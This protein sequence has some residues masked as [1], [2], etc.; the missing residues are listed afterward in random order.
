M[1]I[2]QAF[3]LKSESKPNVISAVICAL[4]SSCRRRRPA[5][6]TRPTRRWPSSK[7]LKFSPP[8]VWCWCP[9]WTTPKFSG[10]DA[11]NTTTNPYISTNILLSYHHPSF[12]KSTCISLF[13]IEQ[14][15]LGLIYTVHVDGLSVPLETVI[16]N[17]LTC[18]IPIAGGSQVTADCFYHTQTVKRHDTSWSGTKIKV[19][20]IILQVCFLYGCS[21]FAQQRSLFRHLSNVKLDSERLVTSMT[22]ASV[23]ARY[24]RHGTHLRRKRCLFMCVHVCKRDYDDNSDTE[25]PAV[26]MHISLCACII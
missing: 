4:V 11:H 18:V 24:H 5:R 20:D 8:R 21:S 23:L 14:N 17:L 26:C 13:L 10:Y 12:S 9:G 1:H 7:L 22:S 25:A 6:R 15:C 3:N 16:G 2:N 19:C